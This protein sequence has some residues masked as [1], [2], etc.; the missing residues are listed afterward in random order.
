MEP[1]CEKDENCTSTNGSIMGCSCDSQEA[2]HLAS[3]NCRA[4][5]TLLLGGG[6]SEVEAAVE[7]R[8]E[9][10]ATRPRVRT[11]LGGCL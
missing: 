7:G 3:F 10:V 2:E 9:E 8:R 4:H 11:V 6:V 1:D 5:T